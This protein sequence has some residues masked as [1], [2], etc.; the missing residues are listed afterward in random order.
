[1]ITGSPTKL[2]DKEICFVGGSYWIHRDS[3]STNG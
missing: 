2:I 1:M 3:S